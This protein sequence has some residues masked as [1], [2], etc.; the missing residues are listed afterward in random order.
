[1]SVMTRAATYLGLAI[2]GWG[3]LASFDEL[4]LHGYRPFEDEPDPAPTRFRHRIHG[5]RICHRSLVGAF[6]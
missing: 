6:H 5:A 1:M 3:G 4:A 2:L